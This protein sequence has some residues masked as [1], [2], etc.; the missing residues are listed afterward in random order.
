MLLKLRNPTA[1]AIG[2][3]AAGGAEYINFTAVRCNGDNVITHYKTDNSASYVTIAA[4]LVAEV[5]N[6]PSRIGESFN[7]TL[8]S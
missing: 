6:I 5:G 7:V 8:S 1:S 2:S 3:I 4:G